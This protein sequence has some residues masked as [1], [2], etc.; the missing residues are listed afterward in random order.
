MATKKRTVFGRRDFDYLGD[1][2]WVELKEDGVHLWR[3]HTKQQW[4]LDINK[5]AWL[6]RDQPELFV[7]RQ[8]KLEP[9]A[10]PVQETINPKK[11]VNS[12]FKLERTDEGQAEAPARTGSPETEPTD[13]PDVPIP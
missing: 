3:N 10:I 12:E 1:T 8:V 9:F 4:H 13:R 6:C 2:W 11:E 5:L 7:L